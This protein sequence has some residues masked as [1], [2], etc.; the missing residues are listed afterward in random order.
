MVH[1]SK[2]AGTKYFKPIQF[3]TYN[4]TLS[5]FDKSSL[6]SSVWGSAGAMLLQDCP[7]HL[8]HMDKQKSLEFPTTVCQVDT[9]IRFACTWYH[10]KK[11]VRCTRVL[12]CDCHPHLVGSRVLPI[13]SWTVK[14]AWNECCAAAALVSGK[15]SNL[16]VDVMEVQAMAC[17]K[18]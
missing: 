1:C 11:S 7:I 15:L 6:S 2:L 17:C 9:T 16:N 4:L 10:V 13:H 5:L 12:S 3:C 8:E 18:W 14:N